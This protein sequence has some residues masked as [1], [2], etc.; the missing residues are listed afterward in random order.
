MTHNVAHL[1]SIERPSITL[2]TAPEPSAETV[3]DAEEMEPWPTSFVEALSPLMR[4]EIIEQLK[5]LFLSGPEPPAAEPLIQAPEPTPTA[6][7]SGS[8]PLPGSFTST[9]EKRKSN[10]K[11]RG[12]KGRNNKQKAVDNR[13][14]L[15]DVS[16]HGFIIVHPYIWVLTPHSRFH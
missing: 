6:A 10:G 9:K 1:N 11:E 14:V 12:G 16:F 2:E 7:E 3:E 4:Q 15:S 13:K 8:T 5:E